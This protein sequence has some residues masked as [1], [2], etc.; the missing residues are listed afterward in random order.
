MIVSVI[1]QKTL[2]QYPNNLSF[3]SANIY[4]SILVTII[5]SEL[6][7]LCNLILLLFTF[8][9]IFYEWS[10]VVGTDE[11]NTATEQIF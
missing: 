3:K 9:I 7:S 8:S 2:V 5:S 11:N 4:N 1:C 10:P 6:N